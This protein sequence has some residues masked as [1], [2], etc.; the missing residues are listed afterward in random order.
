MFGAAFGFVL[1][2][3]TMFASALLTAGFGPWLPYQMIASGFVGLGAG[4]LP[5]ARGRAEIAWLCGWGFVSAFVYGWLMDFAFWPFNL[6]TSTQLSFD[7]HA[8][9]LTNLWHFVLFNM[10]TSMGWN[11]GRALTNVV[12]LALLGGPILR[13]LR[14][15]S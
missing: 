15:A 8:S 11:L 2:T 9:P 6:G 5:R 3:T 4:L 13:V 1:G 7:P 14:R 10:A 12:C